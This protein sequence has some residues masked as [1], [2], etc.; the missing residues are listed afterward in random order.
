MARQPLL[1]RHLEPLWLGPGGNDQ[2]LGLEAVAILGDDAEMV[3]LWR[4]LDHSVK[5]PAEGE[6]V[7]LLA[8][9]AEQLL[10]GHHGTDIGVLYFHE[11]VGLPAPVLGNDQGFQPAVDGRH[12]RSD[13]R[14]P[15]TDDNHVV[16]G[17]SL[18]PTPPAPAG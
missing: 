1:S 18:S 6:V 8:E 14:R 17:P 11:I 10:A 2:G 12:R 5:A 13:A 3:P 7:Q 16:H 4:S 9:P 15:A